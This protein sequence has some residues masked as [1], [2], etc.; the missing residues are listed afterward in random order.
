MKS[1]IWHCSRFGADDLTPIQWEAETQPVIGSWLVTSGID[2]KA[3][4]IGV[5]S[6]APR[7]IRQT[8]GVL[9]VSLDDGDGGAKITEVMRRSAAQKAGVKNQRHRAQRQRQAH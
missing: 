7:R 9:G 4:A 6:V 5:V 1:T 3:L 2:D 8:P